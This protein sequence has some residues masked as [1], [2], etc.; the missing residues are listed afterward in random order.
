MNYKTYLPQLKNNVLVHFRQLVLDV[1]MHCKYMFAVDKV[2]KGFVCMQAC[3]CAAALCNAAQCC[4]IG[5]CGAACMYVYTTVCV[6]TCII[7]CD[8]STVVVFVCCVCPSVCKA[9]VCKN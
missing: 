5:A 4:A 3:L 7:A 6:P 2:I 8:A 9:C 1:Y